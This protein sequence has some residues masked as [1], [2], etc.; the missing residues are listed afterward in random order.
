LYDKKTEIVNLLRALTQAFNGMSESEFERLLDG[1]GRLEFVASQLKKPKGKISEN[2]KLPADELSALIS[3]LQECKTREEAREMLHK[4]SRT[5]L[6]DNLEQMAKLL[7]VHVNKHDKRDAIEDKIVESV[8]GVKLRS[9]AILGLNLK[10]S[11]T[12]QDNS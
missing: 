11:G 2:S 5:S 8:I 7:K 6:K 9:E 12:V 3:Q 4:D 1:T 10:G